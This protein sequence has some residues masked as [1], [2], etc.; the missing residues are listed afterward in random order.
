V[1][2]ELPMITLKRGAV[3]AAPAAVPASVALVFRWLPRRLRPQ[4]AY[5]AGFIIYWLAGCIGF[6]MVVLGP[7]RAARL[8]TQGRQPSGL[9]MLLLI[10]PAV[11]AVSS[12][13]PP[14]RN[15]IDGMLA[16]VMATTGVINA[17]GEELLWRGVFL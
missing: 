8:L 4:A 12:E 15:K 14:N 11:G 3:L 1:R 7:R 16:A 2:A 5:N 10:L 13:L 17:T 9:E 6:S